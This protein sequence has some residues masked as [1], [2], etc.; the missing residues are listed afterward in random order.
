MTNVDGI[1]KP[2]V[3]PLKSTERAEAIAEFRQLKSA[4]GDE[5]LLKLTLVEI[6]ETG[7]EKEVPV[8]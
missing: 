4:H 6:D 8:T 1:G 5:S 2:S 3:I 7:E